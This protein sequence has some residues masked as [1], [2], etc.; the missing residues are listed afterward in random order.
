MNKLT[1]NIKILN[2]IFQFDNPESEQNSIKSA[3]N[4]TLKNKTNIFS[5]GNFLDINKYRKK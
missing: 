2:D 3:N 4:D 5:I 1:L